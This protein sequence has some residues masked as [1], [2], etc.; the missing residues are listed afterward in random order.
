VAA[1]SERLLDLL[2]SVP[3]ACLVVDEG[4]IVGANEEAIEETGIPRV[5]LVGSPLT[6]LVLPEHQRRIDPLLRPSSGA[7][8][9][10]EV[11]LS[12][13]FRPLELTSRAV[14]SRLSLVAVRSMAREVELSALAGGVLTHDQVTGLP[15]RYY[16][17][18]ELH[19]RLT[20]PVGRPLACVAIWVDDLQS[21]AAERGIR[22]SDRILHQVGERLQGRLRAPDL[23]G[24]FDDSGFLV[25]LASDMGAEQLTAV[26]LRLREE[27]AFPVEHESALLSFT[28]S[29]AVAPLGLR[30]PHLERVLSRLE[31]VARRAAT[32]GGGLLETLHF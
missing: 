12:A 31:A 15:N 9:R 25:L 11:R 2:R 21:V 27:I 14:S 13:G 18:E 26:A 23:L 10:A 4:T 6:D 29:M 28:A 32:S 30:R 19:R 8:V 17:L 7:L 24:R 16:L 1:E 5:R 22:A 3:V 20:T